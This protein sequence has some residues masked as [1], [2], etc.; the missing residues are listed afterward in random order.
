MPTATKFLRGFGFY[1]VGKP[2]VLL[3]YR[4]PVVRP[5]YY[6]YKF[7][8]RYPETP[9][10]AK[11]LILISNQSRFIELANHQMYQCRIT[12]FHTTRT[13]RDKTMIWCTF[14]G[15]ARQIN[16]S[17]AARKTRNPN[18]KYGLLNKKRKLK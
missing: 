6:N 10:L 1:D 2:K 7:R 18:N 13:S 8:V 11:A 5:H 12:N 14:K 15:Q 3:A 4:L 17:E 16:T 9:G